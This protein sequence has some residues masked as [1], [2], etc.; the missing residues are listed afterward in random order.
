ML[1]KCPCCGAGNSLDA[2]ISNEEARNALWALAQIGGSLTKNLVMYLGL[3]RPAKSALSQARMATLLNELLPDITAQ[4][5]QRNAKVFD[6]PPQA[7]SWALSEV[8]SA[9][10]AGTLSTPLKSHGYLYEVLSK[11]RG[12]NAEGQIAD[13][14]RPVS[15]NSQMVGGLAKL[16]N[17]K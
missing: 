15:K 10:D 6:A 1:I 12:Q 17:M 7:W 13:I 3:F 5:I 9:R 8:V 16:E 4:R 14:A 11:W 2:L